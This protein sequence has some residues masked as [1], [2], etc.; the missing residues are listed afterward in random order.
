MKVK[1]VLTKGFKNKKITRTLNLGNNTYSKTAQSSLKDLTLP[2]SNN[3]IMTKKINNSKNKNNTYHQT[4]SKN[5]N[6]HTII[7]ANEKS[8]NKNLSQ[9]DEDIKQ[10]QIAVL[11]D[12]FSRERERLNF[13]ACAD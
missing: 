13:S 6:S 7:D 10:N 4:N 9:I 2:I 12:K 5:K 3:N 1:V 11:A 8:L